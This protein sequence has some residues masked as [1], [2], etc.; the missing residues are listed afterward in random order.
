MNRLNLFT[1]GLV[2]AVLLAGSCFFLAACGDETAPADDDFYQAELW[3]STHQIDE[4]TVGEIISVDEN[5]TFLFR[6]DSAIAASLAPKHVLLAGGTT[7]TPRG[8]LRRVVAVTPV[9]DGIQVTTEPAVLQQAFKSLHVKFTR[10]V[11]VTDGDLVWDVA[12]GAKILDSTEVDGVT[13]APSPGHAGRKLVKRDSGGAYLGPFTID[14]YPFNGDDDDSSWEDQVHVSA[15]LEGGI[16]YQFGI[17]FDWPDVDDVLSGDPLP[18][19]VAGFYIK[20]GASAKMDVEGMAKYTWE[21]KDT[22]AH[23]VLGGFWVGPLYFTVSVELLSKLEGGASSRFIFHTGAGANFETGAQYRTDD[24]GKLTPPTFTSWY[25]PPTA[26]ST[27]SAYLKA[28]L[29]PRLRL[30]LYD[31]FGPHV[32]VYAFAQLTADSKADPCWDL[33]AGV[34]GDIGIDLTL[35]GE[36]IAD[37][38]RDFDIW[39]TSIVNGQCVP[40][41]DAPPVPDLIDPTF[42]PWS[43]RISDAANAWDLDRDFMTLEPMIDGHWLIA[44]SGT[45]ALSK[46]TNDGTVLWTRQYTRDN[47]AIQVPLSINRAVTARDLGIMASTFEPVMLAKLDADGR[48]V[49]SWRADIEFQPVE[50]IQAITPA[51]DGTYYV[52]GPFNAADDG[53]SDALIFKVDEAG[54]VLWAKTWGRETINEWVTSVLVLDGDV[55]VVGQSFGL[56]QDPANQSWAM[57]LGPDGS[58]R[59]VTEISGQAATNAVNLRRAHISMNGDIIAAGN[60]GLG[61]PRALLVKIKPDNG[62]E[63]WTG[64][65]EGGGLGLDVTDFFELSDGGYLMAGVWWT[66][67]TDSLWVARSDS[68]GNFGWLKKFA[69]GVEDGSPSIVLT[70]GGGAMLAGYS[71]KGVDRHSTWVTRFPIWTDGITLDPAEASITTETGTPASNP[72]LNFIPSPTP[73]VD[74][75]LTLTPDPLTS[76]PFD[77]GIVKISQ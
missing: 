58:T 62:T 45:K 74:R 7:L 35:W 72:G 54:N 68:V 53:R 77:A 34:Y 33:R 28:S 61:G 73:L 63:G 50:G 23:S 4:T 2:G 26:T 37:Y 21:R 69:D 10:E 44:G 36:T 46:I 40:D 39:D 76:T 51:G 75:L 19:I 70:G 59:W 67:G 17:D 14:Y 20:A 55:I 5:G 43:Y 13:P 29:G 25:D 31:V 30:A 3:P 27:E 15:T 11:D 38:S 48:V 71:D 24:G 49:N 12:P 8:A 16:T 60:Y 18:A 9:V 6:A 66:G 57:R 56:D 22:L 32:S 64:G 42:T 65:N 47:A 1:P 52:G 41:P